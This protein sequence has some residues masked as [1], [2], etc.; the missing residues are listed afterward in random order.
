MLEWFWS[1]SAR[2]GPNGPLFG[3]E[4]GLL[5]LEPN[6]MRM[7]LLIIWPSLYVLNRVSSCCVRLIL[8]SNSG[9]AWRRRTARNAHRGRGGKLPGWMQRRNF[10][11]GGL[12][13]ETHFFQYT[14]FFVPYVQ[15]QLCIINSS[16]LTVQVCQGKQVSRTFMKTQSRTFTELY[17]VPRMMR[18]HVLSYSTVATWLSSQA[19]QNQTFGTTFAQ[20]YERFF[21]V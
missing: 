19:F 21:S 11:T 9:N 17:Y 15:L 14:L 3:H 8:W 16:V 7:R 4:T 13:L 12:P 5:S 6:H 20:V 10:A 18:R 2:A 1:L